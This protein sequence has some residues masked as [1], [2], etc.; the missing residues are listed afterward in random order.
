MIKVVHFIHGLN[1]GGAETLV[2]N[3]ALLLDRARF[4]V[5]VLCYEH[6]GSPYEDVLRQ[7]NIDVIYVCDEMPLYTKQGIIAKMV[8]HYQR[9]WLIRRELRKL[10]PDIVHFH[11]RLSNYIRFAGL[12]RNVRLFY[13]Q[14]YDT[15][16]WEKDYPDDIK[17]LKWLMK[18]Y[19]VQPI[20][21]NKAMKASMDRILQSDQ[22]RILNNGV[23]MSEFQKALDRNAKRNE[24]NVPQDAFVIA[25]VGR[26]DPIKNHE[27]LVKVFQQIKQKKPEAFLL[28]VGRGETEEKVRNQL[29]GAGLAGSYRI[30]HDR[31]DVAEILR[32]CDAAV[33]PSFSEGLALSLIEMQAAGLH[34][35]ASTGVPKDACISNR[36]SFLSLEQSADVWADTLLEMAASKNSIQYDGL[37][38]WDIRYN[39]KQL[40]KMYEESMKENAG[41]E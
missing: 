14:H 30:L 7:N 18:R 5:T 33:F 31:T 13:T 29:E 10:K 11:L 15:S 19:Q 4:Q 20:A 6:C 28:M 35:I 27:F 3:Y 9:Y 1:M 22:T 23:D 34:C 37:E 12:D 32:A 24:L 26:F 25:H 36:L 21:L 41:Q 8:N 17:N 16:F 39:V 40:E 2:K 38:E